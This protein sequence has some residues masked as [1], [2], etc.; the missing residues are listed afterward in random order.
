MMEDQQSVSSAP[1]VSRQ[2]RRARLYWDASYKHAVDDFDGGCGGTGSSSSSH[3]EWIVS[4]TEVLRYLPTLHRHLR[5][6]VLEI[7]CG[8]SLL[9]E[10]IY[11]HLTKLAN[12]RRELGGAEGTVAE[13]PERHVSVVCT[14]IS[15]VAIER[16]RARQEREDSEQRRRPG[17]EYLVADAN[18]LPAAFGFTSDGD[19]RLLFDVVVDKGCADTFQFRAKTNESDALLRRLFRSVH[20]VLRPGGVYLV[21]T[22]RKKVKHLRSWGRDSDARMTAKGDV[23]ATKCRT[24]MGWALQRRHDLG[25]LDSGELKT[26]TTTKKETTMAHDMGDDYDDYDDCDDCDDDDDHGQET[27][28]GGSLGHRVYLHEC[29]KRTAEQEA[30]AAE[31]GKGGA[32]IDDGC[33]KRNDGLALCCG[34]CGLERTKSK[35]KNA[36]SW[37]GHLHW[38]QLAS[39]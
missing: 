38:C 13:E 29:L 32:V 23:L 9:G 2:A 19:G 6:R 31:K 35:Y 28:I 33:R 1:R 3:T 15:P 39:G 7:G 30:A 25:I 24:E 8:D 5:T 14:D 22:P 10:A 27:T 26:K 17:L 36:K 20:A 34:R 21:V 18:D 37:S 11:D 16:L 4:P 12:D